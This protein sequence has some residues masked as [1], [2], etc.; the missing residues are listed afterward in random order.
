V[1]NIFV[2]NLDFKTTEDELH[3][4][5]AAYGP[6]DRV[7]IIRDRD[8]GRSRRFGFVEMANAA[9]GEKA[10]AELNGTRLRDRMLHINEGH[11]RP[12]RVSDRKEGKRRRRHIPT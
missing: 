5:F 10:I 1:K 7:I 4:L 8:T 11:H 6:V 12:V 3:Q 2:G 9:D